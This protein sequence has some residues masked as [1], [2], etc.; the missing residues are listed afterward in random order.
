VFKVDIKCKR[1]SKI[2]G[3]FKDCPYFL[4]GF[5]VAGN[6]N[7]TLMFVDRDI[8][9]LESIV[10]KHIRSREDV[11]DVDV[12][13]IVRGEKDT[14]IP[15]KISINHSDEAP[16]KSNCKECD[17]YKNELCFGCPI[18]GQYKGKIWK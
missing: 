1:P 3:V 11:F 6:R 8:S 9:T 15:F 14:V 5:I 10:D 13:L 18:T 7:L 17:H 16:C 2:L 12:G 4:N